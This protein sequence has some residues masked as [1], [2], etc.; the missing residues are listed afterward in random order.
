MN[1]ANVD[2]LHSYG[3]KGITRIMPN[4]TDM[5]YLPIH[6]ELK[7][8]IDE[9]YQLKDKKN[10]MLFVGRMVENK[11]IFFIADVLQKLK[12]KN[13]PFHM[14]Y[15]GSGL[16]LEKLKNRINKMGLEDQVTFTG[17]I[18]DRDKLGAIY[19]R[20][21]LFIF[22]SVYDTD[23]LVK[24][25]AAAYHTPSLLISGSPSAV[26]TTDNDNA[27]HT[28]LDVE[29]MANRII[30]II[31]DQQQYNAVSKGAYEKLY[32]HWTEIVG[33]AMDAYQQLMNSSLNGNN[34]NNDKK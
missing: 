1:H 11:N 4:G 6:D 10:V 28:T 9:E 5:K 33:N 22:P 25:E 13:F 32:C 30:N 21:D 19:L 24:Y 16:D 29:T 14:V 17:K 27:Y 2:I 7:E 8:K 34:Q 15:V 18:M 12:E 23:G 26:G 3:Y 20:S 31:S